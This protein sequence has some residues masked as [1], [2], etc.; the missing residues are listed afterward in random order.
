MIDCEVEEVSHRVQRL[1]NEILGDDN[2]DFDETVPLVNY[3][4]DSLRALALVT[5]LEHEFGVT[6]TGDVVAQL[7]TIEQITRYLRTEEL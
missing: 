3:G 2:D 6:L 5:E 4:F 7:H 1:I